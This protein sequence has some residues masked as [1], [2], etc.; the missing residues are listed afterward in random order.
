MCVHIEKYV[1]M[2][3]SIHTLKIIQK[4]RMES[5][6]NTF[7]MAAENNNPVTYFLH[8]APLCISIIVR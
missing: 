5:L 6:S 4:L 3:Y 1:K 7:E 2:Q 8:L